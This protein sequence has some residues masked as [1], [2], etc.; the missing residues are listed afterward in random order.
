[1]VKPAKHGILE[2]K[3]GPESEKSASRS[4]ANHADVVYCGHDGFQMRH[5]ADEAYFRCMAWSKLS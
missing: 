5:Q 2:A 1:M 3:A 4:C